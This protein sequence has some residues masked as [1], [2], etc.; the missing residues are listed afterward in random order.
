MLDLRNA[1]EWT[2]ISNM[3]HGR[4]KF[5]LVAAG[6]LLYAVG[7]DSAFTNRNDVDVILVKNIK[8]FSTLLY[9][10]F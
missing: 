4:Y 10:S 2:K 1:T 7:G 3:N 6:N 9:L 5:A 8:L